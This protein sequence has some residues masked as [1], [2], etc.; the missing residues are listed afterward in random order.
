MS[1][2]KV[3]YAYL[4]LPTMMNW[5]YSNPSLEPYILSEQRIRMAVSNPSLF[6]QENGTIITDVKQSSEAL[7]RKSLD[8]FMR[9]R[10]DTQ[11][12]IILVV[13]LLSRKTLSWFRRL[14]KDAWGYEVVIVDA[15]AEP[16]QASFWKNYDDPKGRD[17]KYIARYMSVN[18]PSLGRVISPAELL[19]ELERPI[20]FTKIRPEVKR[21]VIFSDVHGDS[22]KLRST[23]AEFS[24]PETTFAFLGDA[25]DRGTDSAGVIRTLLASNNCLQLL[26]NHEHRLIAW[27]Q[28]QRISHPE[29]SD[30]ARMTLPQLEMAGVT[31]SEIK[32]FISEMGTYL[33]LEFGRKKLLL[34]HA[35]L[36]PEQVARWLHPAKLTDSI[37]LAPS[38]EFVHGL[39]N[40]KDSV[41]SRDIDKVWANSTKFQGITAIHGHRN[42]F[43]RDVMV[44][45]NRS[46]NL[47]D[48]DDSTFRY[49]ILNSENHEFELHIE[50]RDGSRQQVLNGNF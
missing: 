43:D 5:L 37:A 18:W 3:I 11:D 27:Y 17:A 31:K 12:P 28:Q 23:M 47:T 29:V 26:G 20:V 39:S 2:S 40:G 8:L 1:S 36:E 41:Y 9:Q 10:V 14:I 50:W 34:S 49:L 21:L 48:S 30:F 19:N 42:Q 33:A 4:G 38:D 32:Q 15:M 46:F 7:V 35:G 22:K 16:S 44:G 25:I 24:T 13:N 45:N 6:L